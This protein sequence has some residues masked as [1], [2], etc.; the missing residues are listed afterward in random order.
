V[1]NPTNSS[2]VGN[3]KLFFVCLMTLPVHFV[4][5]LRYV[6]DFTTPLYLCLVTLQAYVPAVIYRTYANLASKV[7]R[8][9]DG[10]S[11]VTSVNTAL[12]Q[13]SGKAV[14]LNILKLPTVL[15]LLSTTLP[16]RW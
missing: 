13:C 14:K 6:L 12:Q 11:D 4:V 9:G 8:V 1:L 15:L 10:V 2:T 16:W 3:F 7:T 5:A